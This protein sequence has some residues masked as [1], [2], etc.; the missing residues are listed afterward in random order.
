MS[1]VFIPPDNLSFIQMSNPGNNVIPRVLSREREVYFILAVD[2]ISAQRG[3]RGGEGGGVGEKYSRN[4]LK[5]K[6]RQM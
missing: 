5:Y 4:T 2:D 6:Y 1:K 3:R